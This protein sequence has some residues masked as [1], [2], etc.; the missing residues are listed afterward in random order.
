MSVELQWNS[1][2]VKQRNSGTAEQW[3][4][5][6]VKRRRRKLVSIACGD[7]DSHSIA[8]LPSAFFATERL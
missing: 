2:T 8:C 7:A 5:E 6:T 1:G 4:S 3:N